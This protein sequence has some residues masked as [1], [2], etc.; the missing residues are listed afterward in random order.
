MAELGFEPSDRI[1]LLEPVSLLTK[2]P[3]NVDNIQCWQRYEEGNGHLTC[4]SGVRNVH[5]TSF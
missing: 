4:T 2:L 5:C 3:P 1:P